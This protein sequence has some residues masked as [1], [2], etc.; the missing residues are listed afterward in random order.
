MYI[1]DLMEKGDQVKYHLLQKLKDYGGNLSVKELLKLL[2]IAQATLLKYID[3]VNHDAD[4]DR[5]FIEVSV[6][7]DDIVKMELDADLDWSEVVHFFLSRSI[8]YQVINYLFFNGEYQVNYLADTLAISQSTLHRNVSALNSSLKEFNIQIKN[9][10][11]QGPEHQIRYFLYELYRNIAGPSLFSDF[12]LPIEVEESAIRLRQI[13]HR[14]M[15]N[16]HYQDLRVWV[17]IVYQRKKHEKN[18]WSELE[19][20]MEPY[21]YVPGYE[22]V[23]KELQTVDILSDENPHEMMSM[24]AYLMSMS[25]VSYSFNERFLTFGGP[26]LMTTTHGVR[27]IKDEI[28][29]GT[30]IGNRTNY[31]LSQSLSRLYFYRGGIQ[32]K[33]YKPDE[34]PMFSSVEEMSVVESKGR[35]FYKQTARVSYAQKPEEAG[36][37]IDEC[38]EEFTLH[39]FWLKFKE[40]NSI[41][42]GI[43]LDRDTLLPE[44]TKYYLKDQLSISQRI[45]IEEYQPGK[46]YDY[47]VVDFWQDNLC[48]NYYL[49]K[50]SISLY[51][52]EHI[53]DDLYNML[54]G[55]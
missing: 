3:E 21:E 35:A 18:D 32:L 39:C 24:I 54:N 38:T 36:S 19:K 6:D 7:S 11:L 13:V 47:L 25:K 5:L 29:P 42:L 27:L 4:E 9:G 43:K 15:P 20:L 14:S 33:C 10:E 23:S 41:E 40:P 31:L 12:T 26:V 17:Y 1:I 22:Y 52:I 37:L 49:L 28:V 45:N 8:K 30:E 16:S 44:I 2:N 48:D 55:N 46:D 51:D 53:K 50:G 34:D